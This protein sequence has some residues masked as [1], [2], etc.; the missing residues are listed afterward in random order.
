MERILTESEIKLIESEAKNNPI[1]KF[2]GLKIFNVSKL[3]YLNIITLSD[4]NLIL[5]KGNLDTAY[6]HIKIRHEY[7][8]TQPY[9]KGEGFQAQSK[10]PNDI[11]PAKF[12]KIAD[13]IYSPENL[14]ENNDHKDS[15]KF[16]KYFGAYSF[17]NIT[18]EK[19]NLILYKGTKIIHSLYPQSNKYNKNRNRTKY[20]FSRG[21]IQINTN[22]LNKNKEIHI[23]YFGT[24]LKLKYT[25][26]IEKFIEKEIEEWR[27]LA[28]DGNRNYKFD[29]YIGEKK[30]SEFRGE[31]SER[32]SYQH[33][34]L[35]HIEEL[36]L[37]IERSKKE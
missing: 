18:E 7:W 28:F 16:E 12:I 31:T 33:C 24:D 9:P 3:N 29:Y 34:D 21:I 15:D 26:L 2:Y 14:I 27:I 11:Y 4:R 20:P 30:I 1:F 35:K 8:S 10:F 23:P 17:D 37:Q 22:S 13:S 5:I 6:E 36:I 32:I 25:I 19:I